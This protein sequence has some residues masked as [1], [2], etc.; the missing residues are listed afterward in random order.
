MRVAT[1][2]RGGASLRN[3]VSTS[4]AYAR[5]WQDA[6][7]AAE[8]GG[9]KENISGSGKAK[10]TM[11]RGGSSKRRVLVCAQSNTAVDELVARFCKDG[12]Y[13]KDGEFFRPFLVR[14][15]NVKVVHPS[16]MDIFI[17]NLVEKRL[18]AERNAATVEDSRQQRINL[19]RRKLEEVIESIQVR[20]IS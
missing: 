4:V 1:N 5:A 3:S 20:F 8:M 15:G 7:L 2:A 17:D 16:S 14:V 10:E 9:K 18:V 19:L 11:N 13:G 6:A 12:L